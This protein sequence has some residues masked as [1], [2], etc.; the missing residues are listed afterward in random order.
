VKKAA[1]RETAW[2]KKGELEEELAKAAAIAAQAD[3]LAGGG[4]G[5]EAVVDEGSL[6]AEDRARLSLK[7]GRTEAMRAV[8]PNQIAPG[9]DRMSERE[10]LAEVDSSRRWLVL[11]G[12]GIAVLAIAAVLVYFLVW[13]NPPPKKAALPAAPTAV[14][15]SPP[16]AVAAPAAPLAALPAVPPTAPPPAAPPAPAAPP[17][18]KVIPADALIAAEHALASGHLVEPEGANAVE[19][20]IA[21]RDAGAKPKQTRKLEDRLVRALGI[22]ARNAIRKRDRAGEAAALGGL[23]KLNPRDKA[24]RAR[25]AKIAPKR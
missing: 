17:P 23:L 10:M 7:T 24:V 5:P 8:N 11:I 15:T 1:F 20:L 6:T 13:S 22:Q 14:A 2:F 25:L 3:P 21:A 16:P 19:L 4:T 9:G 12:L 18:E